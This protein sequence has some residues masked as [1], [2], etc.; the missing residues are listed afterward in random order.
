[1]PF[2]KKMRFAKKKAAEPVQDENKSAKKAKKMPEREY[3]T[4][5]LL[6]D[7]RNIDKQIYDI[8]IDFFSRTKA[9]KLKE[10]WAELFVAY[11]VSGARRTELFIIPLSISKLEHEG[12]TYYKI[13]KCNLK[14]FE[15]RKPRRKIETQ[16]FKAWNQY[17]KALFE[18]LLGGKLENTIDFSPL[19]DINSKH[20]ERK[21]HFKLAYNGR[22]NQLDEMMAQISFRFSRL[23]KA[24]I[25]GKD[26]AKRVNEGLVP[27]MLR[28]LRISNLR[29][30]KDIPDSMCQKLFGWDD[31]AMVGY[32]SDVRRSIQEKEEIEIYKRLSQYQQSKPF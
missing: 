3:K 10:L 26:N 2:T 30:E 12:E 17:E 28:H 13:K 32:Y 22:D 19:I 29:V 23:F 31:P 11:Y 6:A 16:I 15:G 7:M 20:P 8:V 5:W 25:V 4:D 24:D 18:F 1:M 14:H 27:H 9:F 21:E